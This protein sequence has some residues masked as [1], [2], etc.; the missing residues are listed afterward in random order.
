LYNK[1]SFNPILEN[2]QLFSAGY[3]NEIKNFV[4]L[5]ENRKAKNSS[6]LESMRATFNLINKINKKH[7]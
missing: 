4:E 5:C 1:N 2:N 3:Y 6:P 7:V